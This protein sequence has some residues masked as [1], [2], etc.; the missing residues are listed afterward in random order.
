MT[1]HLSCK[2]REGPAPQAWEGEA[3]VGLPSFPSP[4]HAA[5]GPLPLP[6]EEVTEAAA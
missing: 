4:S 2:E 1:A 6:P 5:H 3:F